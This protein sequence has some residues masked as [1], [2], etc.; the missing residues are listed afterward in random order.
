MSRTADTVVFLPALNEEA[1]LPDVLEELHREL[2]VLAR[3][4]G[5][6]P[7]AGRDR[8]PVG[9]ALPHAPFPG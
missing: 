6:D 8:I 5:E 2:P 4:R 1:S 9:V 3:R 7:G